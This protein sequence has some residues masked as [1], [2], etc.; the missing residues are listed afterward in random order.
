MP[1]V[2]DSGSSNTSLINFLCEYV[3]TTVCFFTVHTGLCGEEP[4]AGGG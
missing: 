1:P 4:T 2:D 3:S